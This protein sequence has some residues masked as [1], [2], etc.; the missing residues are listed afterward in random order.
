MAVEIPGPVPAEPPRFSIR[1]PHWG[2]LLLATVVLVISLPVLTLW[3][4]FHRE[5]RAVATV[6]P[7]AREIETTTTEPEW[8]RPLLEKRPKKWPNIF[9][10]VIYVNLAGS[11]ISDAEFA[12]VSAFTRL[13]RLWA[14]DTR[15]TDVGLAHIRGL[16][17]LE[18]VW[19][20]N[21]RITDDGLAHL[22]Q[23]TNLKRLSLPGTN[24]T[25]AGLVHVL[26]L[27]NLERLWLD[28]TQVTNN[29]LQQLQEALPKCITLPP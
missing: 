5:Q 29:G 4:P 9:E 1:L 18:S 3:L 19:L 23:L 7:F 10:H 15:V 25:D 24:I 8:L 13:N 6:R 21:S 12:S 16:T 22:S 14:N 11:G 27:T 2:W 20:D 28:Q 17:G 26:S